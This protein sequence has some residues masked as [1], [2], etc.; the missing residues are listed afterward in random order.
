MLPKA[1]SIISQQLWLTGEVAGDWSLASG[2]HIYEKGWKEHPGSCRPGR[3]EVQQDG[4]P[5]PALALQNP[6]FVLGLSLSL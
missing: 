6:V 1:L 4:V 3:Y 2:T 5:G